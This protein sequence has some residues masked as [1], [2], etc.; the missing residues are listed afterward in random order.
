MKKYQVKEGLITKI[1]IGLCIVIFLLIFY[2]VLVKGSTERETSI[3]T[4]IESKIDNVQNT[5]NKI[6]QIVVERVEQ[7]KGNVLFSTEDTINKNNDA[8]VV[9]QNLDK[10]KEESFEHK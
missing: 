10:L 6:L 1:I 9:K 5:T 3:E 7:T 8:K 4:R 2:D